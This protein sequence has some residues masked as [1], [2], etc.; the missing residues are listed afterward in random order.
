MSCGVGCRCGL[1]PSLLWLGCRLVAMAPIRPLAPGNT[2]DA[3]LKRK[4]SWG[5][6]GGVSANFCCVAPHSLF[7]YKTLGTVTCS[8]LCCVALLVSGAPLC[9][10]SLIGIC[11]GHLPRGGSLC[12]FHPPLRTSRLAT[13]CYSH[14]M[15]PGCMWKHVSLGAWHPA[16]PAV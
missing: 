7:G 14:S 2:V 13:A 12:T 1:D 5:L 8:G 10:W 11:L 4:Q 3:A 15:C 9:S 16:P 6:N